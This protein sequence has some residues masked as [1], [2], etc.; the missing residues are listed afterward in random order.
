MA[1]ARACAC[2]GLRRG[3]GL[4]VSSDAVVSGGELGSVFMM[5]TAGIEDDE[6]RNKLSGSLAPAT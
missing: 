6:G 4:V 3:V 5:L 1:G 2:G